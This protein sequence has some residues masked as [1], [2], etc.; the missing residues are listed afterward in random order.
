MGKP[1]CIDL[2]CGSKGGWAKGF[3]S[4]GY[5]VIGFDVVWS[6]EYPGELICAD[7]RKFAHG[8]AAFSDATVIVASPP[9]Q[10]FTRHM[11]PWCKR[12]NPPAPDLSIIAA[13]RQIAKDAGRPFVMENVREAQRYIGPAAWHHGSRYLWGDVPAIMPYVEKS[14]KEHLSSTAI[15]E[16]SEIP[17]ELAAHIARVFYSR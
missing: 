14:R 8:G 4:E 13:C 3:L 9:C 12:M 6:D 7:V 16:R 1:L 17:F 15:A 10:E 5:R 2:C 11:L